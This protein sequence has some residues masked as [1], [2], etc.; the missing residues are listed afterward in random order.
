MARQRFS[1]TVAAD[2]VALLISANCPGPMLRSRLARRVL[3]TAWVALSL[4]GAR[5]AFAQASESVDTAAVL[6]SARPEIEAAN[7]AWLPGL[8]AHDAASIAAAY[9]DSGI[10]VAAN[11]AVVRGREAVAHMYEGRFGRMGEIR[12]GGIVQDGIAVVSSS[13]LY[14]WGRGWLETVGA[15]GTAARSGGSYL[16]V[17][18]RQADGHWRIVRNLSL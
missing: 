9:A 6:R 15:N 13:L 4:L 18:Q 10:F 11:G 8:K 7:A 12:A 14:E 2:V 16:T 3:A 1:W 5:Q 17:W